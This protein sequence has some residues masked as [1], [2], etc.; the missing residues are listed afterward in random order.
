[1]DAAHNAF[2]NFV[3][4]VIAALI[5]VH[6]FLRQ[7]QILPSRRR[8]CSWARISSALSLRAGLFVFERPRPVMSRPRPARLLL[9]ERHFMPHP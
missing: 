1:V 9:L 4:M 2:V 3:E 7:R 6:A 5:V 8:R